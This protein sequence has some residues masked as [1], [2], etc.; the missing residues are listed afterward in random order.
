[1]TSKKWIYLGILAVLAI[2][3]AFILIGRNE[4][5]S[6]TEQPAEPQEIKISYMSGGASD[7]VLPLFVAQEKGFFEEE[8][9]KVKLE[10]M[11]P[12]MSLSALLAGEVDYMPFPLN[13]VIANLKGA[14]V[15]TIILT[16]RYPMFFLVA[17][18][19]LELED[20][21]SIGITFFGASPMHYHALKL[22][23]ENN[24]DVEIIA[25]NDPQATVAFLFRGTTDAI[26][27]Q[28]LK[29]IRFQ[30]SGFSIL[31]AFHDVLPSGLSTTTEKIENNPEE[32]RK[33]VRA[34]KKAREFIESNPEEMKEFILR[35][36][37]LEKT[38][39]NLAMAETAAL[40]FKDAFTRKGVPVDEGLETLIKIAKAGS[41]ENLQDIEGQTVSQE[42]IDQVF[43]FRFVE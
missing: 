28:E 2:I 11:Q 15:K 12:S 38:E 16:S 35:F 43:D 34:V 14:Q 1:M 42:E 7:S 33:I 4:E 8:G 5:A 9:L 41:F 19:G 40:M 17:Q 31:K 37:N 21:K 6:L 20:L 36:Y 27:A 26:L 29:A 23:E 3:L 25:S 22:V 24:L 39:E 13:A 10:E 30:A 32:V 18:P